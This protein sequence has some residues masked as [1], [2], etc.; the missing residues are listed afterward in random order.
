MRVGIEPA[1]PKNFDVGS[2]EAI[3]RLESDE[4][5]A[6]YTGNASHGGGSMGEVR[7]RDLPCHG[8]EDDRPL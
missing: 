4:G 6:N 7:R 1:R 5:I 8:R 3:G 2:R